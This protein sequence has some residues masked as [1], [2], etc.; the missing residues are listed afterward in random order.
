M[1]LPTIGAGVVSESV[2]FLDCLVCP[3]W[4][5]MNLFP[6]RTVGK[7]YGERVVL[8]G[9]DTKRGQLFLRKQGKG[10]IGGGRK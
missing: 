5:K 7:A 2:L 10:G 8:V 9:A 4:E 1:G 6:H 3:Q